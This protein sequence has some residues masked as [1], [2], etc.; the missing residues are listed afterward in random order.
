MLFVLD[1]YDSFT[2]NLVQYLGELGA[3]PVVY[4]ND[5]LT[6]EQVLALK[7]TAAVLSPGPCT[8]GEAGILVPLVKALAG[9]V[10]VLGVCLGHQ[11]IGEAFG[12]RVV[13]ADRLMHGKTCNVI[14]EQDELFDGIPSPLTGMRYHSLVVEPTSLPRDL[15]IT[16]WSADRPRDAEIMAMKHRRYPIYGVQFHPESIGTEHGKRLLENFLRVAGA[17]A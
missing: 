11:A 2:Y 5:V 8:P 17:M 6:V 14:H 13:R 9:N 10:P 3:E 16:A 1:N 15:V 4:R 12:G 7:P